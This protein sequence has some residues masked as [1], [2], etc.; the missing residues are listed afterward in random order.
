MKYYTLEM[1]EN[2]YRRENSELPESEIKERA[3]KLHSQLNTLDIRWKRSNRRFY[4][5][6]ELV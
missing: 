1:L 2:Y 3:K 4:R 6:N 5:N